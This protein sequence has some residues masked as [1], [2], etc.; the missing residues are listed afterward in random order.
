MKRF[1]SIL[2][3]T[4][5]LLSAVMIS[6]P[7]YAADTESGIVSLMNA[8]KIMEGD[9]NGN[10]ELDRSVTRAEIAKIAIS[11]ANEKNTVGFGLKVSPFPDVTYDQWYAP[12]VK[13][14]VDKGYV[15]GYDDFL[16]HPND[17]VTY[18]EA[19]TIMLRVL[20][21]SDSVIQGSYPYGQIARADELDMLDNVSGETGTEMNR[22]SVM[23]LVYNA[24]QSDKLTTQ[25]SNGETA[26]AQGAAGSGDASA[27][28]ASDTA[29]GAKTSTVSD[30]LLTAHGC[31]MIKDVNIIST[32]DQ[33]KD[34]GYN[35]VQTSAGTYK[36]GEFFDSSSIGMTGKI[37]IKDSTDAIAFVP[38]RGD[39]VSSVYLIYSIIDNKIMA[40]KDGAMTTLTVNDGTKVYKG[41][42][43]G[44]FG[45]MKSQFELG[46][47]ISITKTENGDV[48]YLTYIEGNLLGPVTAAGGNWKSMWNVDNA[49]ITRDGV[50]VSAK[51]IQ[52]YD[53]VY[54]LPDMNMVMAYSGKISGIFEKASPNRDIPTSIIV[55]GKEYKLESSAAFNK[56]YSGGS[57]EYGD[58][59]TLLLGK[60]GEVADVV[61]PSYAAT[62]S[63]GYLVETGTKEYSSGAVDS[64]TNYYIKLVQT[65]GNSYEY[66]TNRDYTESKNS[67]VELYF[68]NGYARISKTGA[69]SGTGGKFNWSGK[70][71]GSAKLSPNIE[72]LDVGTRDITDTAAYAKVF[73]QRLDG[74]EIAAKSVLYSHKNSSGEIDTLILDNVTGDSFSYGLVTS[75]EL[76]SS[77]RNNEENISSEYHIIVDGN[78]YT[79][80][81][82]GGKFSVS[83][84]E[85]VVIE[86]SLQRPDLIKAINYIAAPIS[87]LSTDRLVSDGV[88]YKLSD[89]VSV[90]RADNTADAEYTMLSLDEVVKHFDKYSIRAF[91][92]KP[93]DKGGRVR[94]LLVTKK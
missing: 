38:D 26:S 90:Y 19:I 5:V 25:I 2:I 21:Y 70:S 23:N 16:F 83:R 49:K 36:T 15:K 39:R 52:N 59:V 34:I 85:P 42:T 48:D 37:F 8:L 43:E 63:V 47:K 27:G 35:N 60:N 58:T 31:R 84:G 68:D 73:G 11:A 10:M 53:V 12:Y 56:V 65:D 76:K 45:T 86:G 87:S 4:A 1:F 22:K 9:G 77:T 24:M 41:K 88:T 66:I 44:T 33:D 50:S 91:Y 7:V 92:D 89:K 94:V 72:I 78:R 55:S 20:G 69:A 82:N 93:S 6:A 17:T 71:L 80:S 29:A 46:D 64:Y 79:S 54:Y 18:E 14:A 28:G 74:V 67:V 81:V 51:E 13:A 62:G 57:F 3:S 32:Y 61:S 75:A 30:G 40:Y